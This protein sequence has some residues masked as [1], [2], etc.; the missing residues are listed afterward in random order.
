M[1][2]GRGGRGLLSQALQNSMG[3]GSFGFDIQTS[4]N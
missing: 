4:D 2:V 1:R 3:A